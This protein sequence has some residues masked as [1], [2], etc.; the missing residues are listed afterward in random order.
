M[1][2]LHLMGNYLP[3][4]TGHKLQVAASGTLRVEASSWTLHWELPTAAR[5]LLFFFFLI[6]HMVEN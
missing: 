2:D 1:V 4:D 3:D 5:I 6:S